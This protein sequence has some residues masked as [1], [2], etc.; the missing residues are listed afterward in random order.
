MMKKSKIIISSLVLLFTTSAAHADSGSVGGGLYEMMKTKLSEMLITN[1]DSLVSVVSPLAEA[2]VLLY[3]VILGYNALKG[4]LGEYTT[5]AVYSIFTIIV[6]FSFVFETNGY[7][8]WLYLP[9]MAAIDGL[10]QSIVVV[11][12]GASPN[13]FNSS[14]DTAFSAIFTSI[15]ALSNTADSWS[16]GNTIKTAIAVFVLLCIYGLNYILYY[17]LVII[18]TLSLH[19]QLIMGVFLI[20]L[21]A[22]K[23]TRFIF[24][25]WLK[26]MLTYAL[27]PVYG[28]IVMSITLYFFEGVAKQ[29]MQMDLSTG[30]V[31]TQHYALAVLIGAFGMW[32]LFKVPQYAASIT[33][34]TAGG[35][36]GVAG[37][38]MGGAA[39]AAV[40]GIATAKFLDKSKGIDGQVTSRLGTATSTG[41]SIAGNVA[42]KAA[43][44]VGGYNK[45]GRKMEGD[46]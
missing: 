26:D 43:G 23:G 8:E 31:F 35:V 37:A 41:M 24:F 19:I 22:F 18:A 13:D 25:S 10:M 7:I 30:D 1:Y 28:A 32:A 11:I 40:G 44:F 16:I 39:G 6:V 15:E 9:L 5:T 27:W 14:I 45:Y 2:F 34:G 29:M 3:V 46:V 42:S 12:S 20:F 17:G 36:G 38:L 21:S 4:N 33:G